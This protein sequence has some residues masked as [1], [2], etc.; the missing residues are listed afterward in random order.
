MKL[1]RA[2]MATRRASDAVMVVIIGGSSAGSAQHPGESEARRRGVA[3]ERVSRRAPTR[4]RSPIKSPPFRTTAFTDHTT[5]LISL[6]R[7]PMKNVALALVVLVSVSALF[8]SPL[9]AAN[10]PLSNS[11][12]VNNFSVSYPDGWSTIRSGGVTV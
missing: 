8:V 5:G 12:A 1:I 4:Q 7:S 6:R 3:A 9:H 11:V 2:R 10:P